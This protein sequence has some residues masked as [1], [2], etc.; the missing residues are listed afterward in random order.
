MPVA[1][2]GSGALSLTFHGASQGVTYGAETSTNLVNWTTEGPVLSELDLANMRT[3]AV[4]RDA[5]RR[6]LRLR[7]EIGP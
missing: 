7:F 2:L 1:I 5:P 4:Y 3:A 6:F